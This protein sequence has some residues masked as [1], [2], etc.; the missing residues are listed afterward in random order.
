[1]KNKGLRT[2]L[3]IFVSLLAP[4]ILAAGQLQGLPQFGLR[5]EEITDS[6]FKHEVKPGE[7]YEDTV[8]V[9][10]NGDQDMKVVVMTAAGHSAMTGGLAFPHDGKDEVTASWISFPDAGEVSVPGKRAVPLH[11]SVTVPEGTAPGEYV[12]GFVAAPAELPDKT[13]M[14][15]GF[16]VQVVPEAAV[17]VLITVPGERNYKLNIDGMTF[18]ADA[19]YWHPV[20]NIHNIGN[21]GWTGKGTLKVWPKGQPD[22]VIRSRDFN[23]G[24]IVQP[25]TINYP[26]ELEAFEAGSYTVEVVLTGETGDTYRYVT[27]ITEAESF[28]PTPTPTRVP[29]GQG[30]QVQSDPTLLYVVIALL[31][32]I[33]I[34]GVTLVI[35]MARRNRKT[36][37]NE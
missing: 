20:I 29:A 12:A 16:A 33:V 24:Y 2:A 25:E 19:G 21:M 23:V 11:F 18:S 32:L 26:L 37:D 15:Q 17:T 3:T 8:L 35:V 9:V 30:G 7:T 31:V 5:P 1:M 6:Y 14:G 36:E 10:N 34:L 27:D 13:D 28:V 4:F 22:N